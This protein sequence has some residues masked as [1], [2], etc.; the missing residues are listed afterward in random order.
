MTTLDVLARLS[1]EMRAVLTKQAE[2]AGDAFATDVDLD[3]MRRQYAAERAYWNEGGPTMART[4]DD[5]VPGPSGQVQVRCH[6]PRTDRGDRLPC[7]VYL[8]GG[9][10]VVGDLD[11]HDRIMRT[12]AELSGAAVVGVDYSLSPEAKFPQAVHEAAAAVRH[13]QRHGDRWGVDP[14]HVSLAGD[15]G[16]AMLCLAA[17][18]L[19]RDASRHGSG[20][21]CLLLWYGMYGLRDSASR[22]LLGGPWDGLAPADLAYYLDCYTADPADLTSPYLDCLSADLAGLPPTY[23]SAVEL[24]PL[25]D[26]SLVLA[27]LLEAAGVPHR[28]RVHDRVL[29]GFLHHS[30]LLPEAPEAL[31]DG[32]EFYRAVLAPVPG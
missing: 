13:V 1:P 16:G 29:H 25:R 18:L 7:I 2:L 23:V 27:Q 20:L 12:L 11:T 10:F 21:R 24:D 17:A 19:L 3:Q 4:V 26:D 8:H 32:A 15:S 30:R 28:L 31:A 6:V 22:R 5:V 14:A 9:G